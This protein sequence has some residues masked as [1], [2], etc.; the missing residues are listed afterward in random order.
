VKY[1]DFL[2]NL[3]TTIIPEIHEEQIQILW[4]NTWWDGPQDGLIL[5]KNTEY[6][7]ENFS[8][9]RKGTDT[10]NLCKYVIIKLNDEQ[11]NIE[12]YWHE[13][14]ILE[15]GPNYDFRINK[16]YTGSILIEKQ[17]DFYLDFKEKYTH[18]LDDNIV[19]GWFVGKNYSWLDE[20]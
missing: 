14:F 8:F 7:F 5:Y 18:D 11:L 16:I 9:T 17:R 3:N 15:I 6:Y 4:A 2:R 10:N 20:Q 19:I 1:S 13:R 12:K